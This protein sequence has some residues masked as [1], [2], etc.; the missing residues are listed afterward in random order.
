MK[1]LRA[2]HLYLGCMFAPLL[3]FFAIS[4]IWQTLGFRSGFLQKLSSIHTQARWK[5]GSELGSLPLRIVVLIMA[6]SFIFTTVLGVVMAFKL[7]QSRRAA[8]FCLL[9][10][11]AIPSTLVLY[12]MLVTAQ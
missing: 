10:G 1:K 6:V 11:V 7:G 5:D 12:R 9:G 2:V 4:G 3:L 8:L